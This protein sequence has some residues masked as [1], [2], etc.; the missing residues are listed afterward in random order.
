[1]R[2]LT[3][4]TGSELQLACGVEFLEWLSQSGVVP[5]RGRLLDV[6]EACLVGGDPPRLKALARRHGCSMPDPELDPILAEYARRSTLVGDPHTP[7][8]FLGEFLQ[9]TQVEYVAFDVVNARGAEVFDLNRH[10]LHQSQRG[11]FDVVTNFGTTEHVL[12]Q[13]NAFRVIHDALKVGGYVFHQVPSSGYLNH[14]YFCYNLLMFEDLAKANGYEIVDLWFYGP[15]ACNTLTDHARAYPGVLD[16]KKPQNNVEAFRSAPVPDSLI[17]V[18]MRKTSEA[19]FRAGLELRTSAGSLE[20]GHAVS[21]FIE[22]GDEA[23]AAQ[24]AVSVD[25]SAPPPS[26]PRTF[27]RAVRQFFNHFGYDITPLKGK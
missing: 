25:I 12:N 11:T 17:D 9:L 22:P 3:I 27:Q 10:S 26:L 21:R 5:P 7:T 18:L 23:T 24:G 14:G 13:Y 2:D 6:G 19:P 1:M 4:F 20:T 8:L 16:P 15:G